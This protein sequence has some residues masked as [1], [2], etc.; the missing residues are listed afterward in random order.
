MSAARHLREHGV[1][2]VVVVEARSRIGVRTKHGRIAGIDIDLG[3]MWMGGTQHRLK[4]LAEEC[5][6]ETYPTWLG[7]KAVT[8]LAGKE[9]HAPGDDLEGLFSTVD[10]AQYVW[11]ERRMSV[12]SIST[13]AAFFTT[14]WEPQRR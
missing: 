13:G 14:R 8:R 4:A 12:L 10:K 6:V 2:D 7:G 11:L 1:D 5:G 3:G 9:Y